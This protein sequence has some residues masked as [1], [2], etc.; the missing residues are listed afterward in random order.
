[1][2]SDVFFESESAFFGSE[3][4]RQQRSVR[5]KLNAGL[6]ADLLLPPAIP[7]LVIHNIVNPAFFILWNVLLVSPEPDRQF[8][9]EDGLFKGAQI[10]LL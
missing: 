5:V 10:S 8:A 7:K 2:T 3:C 1:M 4:E 9:S 6:Y